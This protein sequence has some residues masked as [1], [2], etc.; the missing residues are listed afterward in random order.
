MASFLTDEQRLV[1]EKALSDKRRDDELNEGREKEGG[2]Q[3][4]SKPSVLDIDPWESGGL[5]FLRRPSVDGKDSRDAK[6]GGSGAFR[7]TRS[8]SR[9]E[10]E[11]LSGKQSLHLHQNAA[12]AK[13]KKEQKERDNFVPVSYSQS[14]HAQGGGHGK[15]H[16]S[17]SQKTKKSVRSKGFWK[18]L[19]SLPGDNNKHYLDEKD[20]NYDPDE[21]A[22]YDEYSAYNNSTTATTAT[23][24]AD[25]REAGNGT[26][27]EGGE[28]AFK[29]RVAENLKEFLLSGDM[30]DFKYSMEDLGQPDLH[31][32]VVKRAVLLGL[33]RSQ[34]EREMVSQLFSS[35][36]PKTLSTDQFVRGFEDVLDN[37]EDI[38]L[39][40][41]QAVDMIGLFIAR[42][43][44][45]DILPRNFAQKEKART[46]GASSGGD[47]G[48]AETTERV[49]TCVDGHVNSRHAAERLLRCWGAGAGREVEATKASM[50]GLLNEYIASQDEEEAAHC[51]GALKVPFFHHEC[52]KQAIVMMLEEPSVQPSLLKLLQGFSS[53]GLISDHQ[54][55]TGFHRV[56]QRLPDLE[57]DIPQ[58]ADKF[59]QVSQQALSAD[60][61]VNPISSLSLNGH[62]KVKA[63]AGLSG[64]KGDESFMA[65]REA[66]SSLL[67]EYFE[68][69]DVGE[70]MATLQELGHKDSHGWFVKRALTLAMDRRARDKEAL[71]VLLCDL[72]N[73][74]CGPAAGAGK[75][76]G[77]DSAKRRLLE[78]RDI[79]EG[80]TLVLQSMDDLILDVPDVVTQSALFLA[81]AVVE[82][83]VQPR[84]IE[85][86]IRESDAG[87]CS[88]ESLTYSAQLL[89]ARHAAERLQRCWGASHLATADEM[90]GRMKKILEEFLFSG[91]VAE[92][93]KCL[94]DLSAAF[95]HHEFVKLA[96]IMMLE[97]GFGSNAG[98]SAEA[99]PLMGLLAELSST[100]Q[101]SENQIQTG[102]QRV[103]QAL[104]DLS[105]D[106]PD[107][108][109]KVAQCVAVAEKKGWLAS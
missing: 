104:D 88:L 65:F 91:D 95:F 12:S 28:A 33:G 96:L 39:D 72:C 70:A 62:G 14:T 80:F 49:L 42:A 83:L 89:A 71:C 30:V 98:A 35:L 16:H 106:Y 48:G 87:S 86:A 55:A 81:R 20:P 102:F 63:E 85:L 21:D 9:H 82:D 36:Y 74:D 13:E 84:Y 37:A 107:A 101:L 43:V 3:A 18:G 11:L 26:H 60:L 77:T 34:R 24:G 38:L 90:K 64:G 46:Q 29:A 99:S 105:L 15:S 103:E 76:N 109:A 53:S 50:H 47:R 4:A 59:D 1:L 73:Y 2:G 94:H 22:C 67:L 61:L 19:V 97:K 31:H 100:G 45:D 69:G 66:A 93:S 68:S 51:L 79:E 10:D 25:A 5:M 54:M 41:P 44:I 27:F 78:A 40:H 6:T 23:N 32:L 108:R 52:V 57:L 75:A 92:A 7:I 58:A 17:H 8:G 56:R